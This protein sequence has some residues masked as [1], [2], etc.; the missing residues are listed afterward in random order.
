MQELNQHEL[1][2][3]AGGNFSLFGGGG[4]NPGQYI[5]GSIGL[6]YK[7]DN[8]GFGF[9]VGKNFSHVNGVGTN[10]SS[11]GSITFSKKW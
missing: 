11:F 9:T 2:N 6:A 1:E 7:P 3:V 4:G 5:G 10:S 8:G